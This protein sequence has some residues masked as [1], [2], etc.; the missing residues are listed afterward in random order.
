MYESVCYKKSFLKEVILRIDFPSPL[1]GHEKLL[2][3]SISKVIL[4]AFP[5]METQQVQEQKLQF[6][7]SNISAESKEVTQWIFYGKE[8]EKSILLMPNSISITTKNYKSFED[9]LSDVSDI[10]GEFF[11]LYPELGASRVGLRFINVLDPEGNDPLSWSEYV[12]EKMLGIIDFHNEEH[13]TRVFHIL[14]YNYDGQAIKYQFG[15]A[16]PDFPAL[17]KRKQFVLDIDSSF[18][19]IFNLT[20]IMQNIEESHVKIQELF[21]KSI[22]DKTK[23]LMEPVPNV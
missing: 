22:T 4:K 19:G 16:N 2:P 17:I 10:F 20:E 23:E 8:R 7:G 1:P 3:S 13:L 21:E 6:S 14:E 9:L 15:I 11:K 5:I 12:D 18:N